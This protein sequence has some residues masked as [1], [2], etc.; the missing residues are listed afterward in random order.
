[1]SDAHDGITGKAADCLRQGRFLR[2]HTVCAGCRNCRWT[3]MRPWRQRRCRR[4]SAWRMGPLRQS[5]R[6][7]CLRGFNGCR[8]VKRKFMIRCSAWQKAADL[9]RRRGIAP[10]LLF[11]LPNE[12]SPRPRQN[13]SRGMRC[14]SV[15]EVPQQISICWHT[16]RWPKTYLNCPIHKTVDK[17]N[18]YLYNVTCRR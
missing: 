3:R 5:K 12:E 8:R 6:I 10:L 17:L 7:R 11:F 14:A 13:P 15:G 4:S 16:D 2:C 18:A 9:L 1:M